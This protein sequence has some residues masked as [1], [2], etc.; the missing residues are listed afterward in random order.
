MDGFSYEDF[1]LFIS[2][3]K[4]CAEKHRN[5][6]RKDFER[7]PYLNHPVEVAETLWSVGRVREMAVLIA[8]LLHDVIEDTETAPKE[9]S[10]RFGDEVLSMVL[11]VTDD[12]MLPKS[13]RKELQVLHA[14]QLSYG[15]KLIK[16]ADKISNVRDVTWSHPPDWSLK[17][18]LEY[19]EWSERVVKGLGVCNAEL[20]ELFYNV[21]IEGKKE[22]R[23][24]ETEAK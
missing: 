20:E 8:A 3:L 1:S 17:R 15:A 18:R 6:R 22:L 24:R 19:L 14:A 5:Q 2:A 21:L 16:I 7:T 11:E 10:S 23:A 9:I 13:K 4:F 12:K